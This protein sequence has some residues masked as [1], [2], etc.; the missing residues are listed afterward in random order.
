M[1]NW[2]HNPLEMSEVIIPFITRGPTLYIDNPIGI[3]DSGSQL[4]RSELDV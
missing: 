4:K 1:G 3:L 2:G